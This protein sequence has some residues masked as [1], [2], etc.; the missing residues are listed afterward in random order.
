V[1][2]SKRKYTARLP[3][4]WLLPSTYSECTFHVASVPVCW[5]EEHSAMYEP[6]IQN[7]MFMIQ[8]CSTLWCYCFTVITEKYS[9][10]CI[11]SSLCIFF[12]QVAFICCGPYKSDT[13]KTYLQLW[14]PAFIIFYHSP[15]RN[16]GYRFHCIQPHK[17]YL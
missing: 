3:Q 5:P 2:W 12:T 17:R 4:L 15:L 11:H 1:G 13:V 8:L 9:E 10:T 14:F 16:D 6:G 7:G